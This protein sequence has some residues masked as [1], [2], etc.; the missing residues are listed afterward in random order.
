ML[1]SPESNIRNMAKD[2]LDHIVKGME[3]LLKKVSTS[4]EKLQWVEQISLEL[5]IICFKS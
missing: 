3:N 1:N 2:K 4:H 5:V